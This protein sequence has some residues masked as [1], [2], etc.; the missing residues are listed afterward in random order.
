MVAEVKECGQTWDV[1]GNRF[2]DRL[3]IERLRER[4]K[5]DSCVFGLSNW[6]DDGGIY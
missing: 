3:G 2:A 5:V 4:I 6:L 1:F